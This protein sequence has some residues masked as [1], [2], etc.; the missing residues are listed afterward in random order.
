MKLPNAEQAIV[1]IAKLREYSLDATH[2]EGK[3]KAR[4]FA[5][6]L[7]IGADDADWL[8]EKLLEAAHR[9]ECI[10]G[11]NTPFGQRYVLDF[12]LTKDGHEARVRS[13]WNVRPG[14]TVPRLIT[15][16]VL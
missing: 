4:V 2:E 10:P 6:A 8:R 12:P 16:Y 13:V 3:H 5:A 1:E 15:C 7:G 9:Y 11:R 14:E